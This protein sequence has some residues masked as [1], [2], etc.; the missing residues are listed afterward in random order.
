MADEIKW[1]GASGKSNIY[2][3]CP[4]NNISF[5]AVA[6]NY[7]VAKETKP[8][9]FSPL[10]FGETA[11]L[12]ERFDNHHKMTC[13]TRNG[14]THIHAHTNSSGQTARLAEET[15]LIQQWN[16]TCNG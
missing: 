10:Y 7:C 1:V 4:I 14:A 5:Q 2:R 16:P 13:F 3:T 8:G 11:D 9:Y 15:D 6:G 12:S